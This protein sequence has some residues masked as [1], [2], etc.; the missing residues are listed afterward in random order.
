MNEN[1]AKPTKKVIS[2]TSRRKQ[3]EAAKRVIRKIRSGTMRPWKPQ[4]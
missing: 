3:E 2:Q 1:E 4:Q